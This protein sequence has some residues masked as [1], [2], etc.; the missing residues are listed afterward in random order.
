MDL[1]C[2]YAWTM[3]VEDAYDHILSIV[4]R[5]L[6]L[7]VIPDINTGPPL[8]FTILSPGVGAYHDSAACTNTTSSYCCSKQIVHIELANEEEAGE[9]LHL[10]HC[11]IWC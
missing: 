1:M 2:R 5:A 7:R 11:F 8:H 6:L 9:V 4:H 10:E 3:W